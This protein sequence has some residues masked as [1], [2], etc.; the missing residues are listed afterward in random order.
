MDQ[1]RDTD[2]FAAIF[3]VT[4][5]DV[6]RFAQRRT[7]PER[8]EDI[9]AEAFLVAWRRVAELPRD[10]DSA[11]AWLFGIAR[12]VLLNELRSQRRA[13]ALAVRL[14]DVA[15]SGGPVS[16]AAEAVASRLDLAQAWGRL[17]D[18]ESEVLGLAVF[19]RLTAEQSAAVLGTTAGAYRV[20]LSRAR[21]ALRR[22]LAGAAAEPDLR[23]A[24]R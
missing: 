10:L 16:D 13:D 17:T 19:E 11:R 3:E 12:N 20:R 1:K 2:R 24:L 6:V 7:A 5:A 18:A 4:H 22:H 21:A 23:E 14:A 15:A 8:G 9:A